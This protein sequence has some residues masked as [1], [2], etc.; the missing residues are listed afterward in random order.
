[1]I[2]VDFVLTSLT[3]CSPSQPSASL[4]RPSPYT[5]SVST[6][7]VHM[8]CCCVCLGKLGLLQPHLVPTTIR[9]FDE[10]ITMHKSV[11]SCESCVNR[12]FIM[13][14]VR[15]CMFLATDRAD[16]EDVDA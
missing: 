16:W 5:A 12:L 2:L 6:D 3:W 11:S 9:E 8:L 15:R 7:Y 10:A 14:T 13:I 4:T 1:M